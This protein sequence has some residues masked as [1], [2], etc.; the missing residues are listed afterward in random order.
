MLL[1]HYFRRTGYRYRSDYNRDRR[2]IR[3]SA[4]WKSKSH[5]VPH[6]MDS[7]DESGEVDFQSCIFRTNFQDDLD[8]IVRKYLPL[9]IFFET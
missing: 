6:N 4:Y 8:H 1:R 7:D 2:G 3:R 9:L 5:V